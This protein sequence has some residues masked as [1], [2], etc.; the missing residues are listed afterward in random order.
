MKP[1]HTDVHTVYCGLHL[2]V[3]H[4]CTT[5]VRIRLFRVGIG[6]VFTTRHL[7]VSDFL[8]E[9][10][11]QTTEGRFDPSTLVVFKPTFPIR[12]YYSVVLP[13]SLR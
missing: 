11:T 7:P 10:D 2:T 8:Y 9:T 12:C 5:P 4:L 3:R 13:C 1:I 6:S